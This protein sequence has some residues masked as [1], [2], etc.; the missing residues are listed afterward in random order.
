MTCYVVDRYRAFRKNLPHSYSGWLSWIWRQHV[1]SLKWRHVFPPKHHVCNKL[2]GVMYKKDNNLHIHCRVELKSAMKL[3][4]S[5]Q[6][7]L[8]RILLPHC[9]FVRYLRC[10][11]VFINCA[12]ETRVR[13]SLCSIN[14]LD[15]GISWINCSREKN[16]YDPPMA[17][18]DFRTTEFFVEIIFRDKLFFNLCNMPI[19]IYIYIYIN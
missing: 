15:K 10:I 9:R 1:V 5:T 17:A 7:N 19:Y 16:L 18:R 13:F 8:R 3:C 4:N 2:H 6:I 11:Y 12:K 14:I